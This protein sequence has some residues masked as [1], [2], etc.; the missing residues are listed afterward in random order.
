M[1]ERPPIVLVYDD[2]AK[3]KRRTEVSICNAG[4]LKAPN[5]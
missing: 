4:K 1:N 3:G 5:K 2:D